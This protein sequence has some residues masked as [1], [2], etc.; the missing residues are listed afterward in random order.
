MNLSRMVNWLE[1]TLTGPI[2]RKKMTVFQYLKLY[3]H[4]C[5]YFTN[6]HTRVSIVGHS[7]MKLAWVNCWKYRCQQSG[8]ARYDELDGSIPQTR[9]EFAAL[10]V[11]NEVSGFVGIGVGLSLGHDGGQEKHLERKGSLRESS[12][13]GSE[14]EDV[15][16]LL[17]HQACLKDCEAD[18]SCEM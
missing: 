16:S 17:E 4:M 10:P 6:Q 1:L 13:A 12:S 14:M 2:L 18:R 11:Q 7:R 3:L 8:F 9:I 15:W 5:A